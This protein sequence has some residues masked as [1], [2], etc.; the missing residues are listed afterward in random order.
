MEKINQY[1]NINN[2]TILL[3][4]WSNNRKFFEGIRN[5]NLLEKLASLRTINR[6]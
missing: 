1:I 2:G 3:N 5:E 6:K 4:I